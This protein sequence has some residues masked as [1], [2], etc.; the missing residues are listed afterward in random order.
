MSENYYDYKHF[1]SLGANC[2]VAEDLI[3]LG[4][5]NCSYPFDWLFSDDFSGIISVIQNDF[6]DFLSFNVLLQH[7]DNKSRYYNS[8]YKFSFYHD[9]NKYQSLKSQISSVQEK[10]LRRINRFKNDICEPSIF[11][12]YII[13]KNDISYVKNNYQKIDSILKSFCSLNRIVYISHYEE[14]TE[15]PI[16]VYIVDKDTEDWI[17]RS[18]LLKNPVLEN[19]LKNIPLDQKE[20]NK[21]FSKKTHNTISLERTLRRFFKKEYV[22]SQIKK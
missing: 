17:T 14:L 20:S 4:L 6:S 1:V 3:K 16:D 9:F 18:P 8:L 11:F 21:M 22:H 2:Y 13:S 12:R 15:L 10:Y 5:R 7:S 19:K